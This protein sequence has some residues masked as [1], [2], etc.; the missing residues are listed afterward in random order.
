MDNEANC[1]AALLQQ[2]SPRMA[3]MPPPPRAFQRRFIGATDCGQAIF[4]PS[5]KRITAST[6]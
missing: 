5:A 6:T 2:Q 4:P 1:A 3:P